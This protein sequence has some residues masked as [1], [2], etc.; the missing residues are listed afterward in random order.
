MTG[1]TQFQIFTYNSQEWN[2][3]IDAILDFDLIL[4]IWGWW[5][6]RIPPLR[7]EYVVRSKKWVKEGSQKSKKIY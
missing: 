5:S 1:T 7:T 2:D 4:T 6:G 3:K